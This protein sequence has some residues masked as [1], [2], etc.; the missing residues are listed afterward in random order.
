MKNL[1]VFTIL[2]VL[3]LLCSLAIVF[4]A[5]DWTKKGNQE[6]KPDIE[7]SHTHVWSDT[8]TIGAESHWYGCEGCEQKKD[9]SNHSFLTGI[10]ECGKYIE[11]T[12]GLSYTLRSNEDLD[13]YEVRIGEAIEEEN[14]VI[15]SYFQGKPV[16]SIARQGFATQNKIK[17]V[18]IPES[19]EVINYGAFYKAENLKSVII[20]E[21]VTTIGQYAFRDCISL[22]QINLPDSVVDLADSV[23][24][25]CTAL[26]NV[27]LSNNLEILKENLFRNCQNLEK[28]NFGTKTKSI[29]KSAFQ[30]C[31]SILNIE[32]PS[33]VK[34]IGENAFS[35]A[36]GLNSITLGTQIESMGKNVFASCYGLTIY[37]ESKEESSSWN[38]EWNS[39]N[40]PVVYDSKN[41]DV[42]NDGY[43]YF[44]SDN[45]R[46]ALKDNI[47]I[48]AMQ[49]MLLSGAIV[50]ADT[51]TYKGDFYEVQDFYLMSAFANCENIESIEIG[52]NITTI[53][54]ETFYKCTKLK[55][56]KFGANIVEIESWAFKKCS[57]LQDI[58]FDGSIEQWKKLLE[59]S[60]E[61]WDE[62]TGN[63]IVHCTDGKISSN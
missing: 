4:V 60:A 49:S 48:V 11:G 2:L 3:V 41:N 44:V 29:E 21:S 16:T 18:V 19:V 58:Y 50:I 1:K 38:S 57:A 55:Q 46:Y 5:C 13:S 23:F 51:L 31:Q 25:N 15:A 8:L 12:S 22:K 33:S 40:C 14:I 30:N 52:A 47:A 54:S 26:T 7:P 45:V 37:C 39:S 17:S 32:L 62:D 20:P 27:V 36:S 42:A 6:E 53:N 56:V 24:Y 34:S 61:D 63:Y 43:I 35:Y 10:C 59:K 28:I 9:E